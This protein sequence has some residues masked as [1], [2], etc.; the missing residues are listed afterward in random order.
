MT[1][2]SELTKI[3]LLKNLSQPELEELAAVMERRSVKEGAYALRAKDE[4]HCLMFILEGQF[5]VELASKDE[6]TITLN[7]LD[8]GGVFGEIALLTDETRSADV[9]ALEDSIVLVLSQQHFEQHIVQHPGLSLALLRQLAR[10]LRIVSDKV[11]DLV[12]LDVY[13]RL[14]RVLWS[15][16]EE[17]KNEQGESIKIL[18]ERPAHRELGALAGTTRE[19]TSRALREL[20]DAGHIVVDGKQIVVRSL[21]H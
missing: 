5:K 18:R 14:A 11:G 10:Q 17:S 20:E 6:R 16:G 4:G 7:L 1:S 13:R 15:L 8:Q 12:L 3:K 19:M 2:W 9:V 21:P